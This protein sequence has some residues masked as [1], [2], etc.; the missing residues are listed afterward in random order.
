MVN[1]DE[2]LTPISGENP[3]GENLEYDALYQEMDSLASPIPDQVS[4]DSALAGRGPD[5][6]KLE[7]NCLQLWQRTRD[8]RVAAFLVVAESAQGGL[9]ALSSSIRLVNFLVSD[10]W[11]VFYPRLD[12]ED[13][14]DS[15]ERLN[16]LAMLSPEAG[17]INDPVMFLA[18]FRLSRLFPSLPYTIRDLMIAEGDLA[19][20][21]ENR[22]DAG[23]I[24]AEVLNA[25]LDELQEQQNLAKA[26]KDLLANLCKTMTEKM[27]GSYVLNMPTLLREV[28]YL[29][30][31]WTGILEKAGGANMAKDDEQDDVA[32]RQGKALSESADARYQNIT[33]V[34]AASR[35][36][37]LLLL[38]KGAE[39]FQRMEPSSPIP[40]LINRAIRFSEMNF[41][42]LLADIAPDALGRGKDILGIKEA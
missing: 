5:W 39:Y 27:Q 15:L 1:I 24:A 10:M 23:L 28:D 32:S 21:V 9:A 25:P 4:G 40:L 30:R 12:P 13:G 11:D 3:A 14:Y 20:G 19:A 8:L 26:T 7:Q 31:F 38:R 17:A 22:V 37:A 29:E 42:D 35:E 36:D 16:I 18:H 2:L 6:K 33:A 34:R 41:M